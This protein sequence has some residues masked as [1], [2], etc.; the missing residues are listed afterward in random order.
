MKG[1]FEFVKNGAAGLI[2]QHGINLA[3]FALGGISAKIAADNSGNI[4]GDVFGV[5]AK[6]IDKT[7]K[8]VH[9]VNEITEDGVP[10]PKFKGGPFSL[11]TKTLFY[12]GSFP[13]RLI[14]NLAHG[15]FKTVVPGAKANGS[16]VLSPDTILM[17]KDVDGT[18]VY[19][20][21][22]AFWAHFKNALVNVVVAL[23]I[24]FIVFLAY[25]LGEGLVTL[26]AV[27]FLGFKSLS[28]KTDEDKKLERRLLPS[29]STKSLPAR[30][31]Y[32]ESKIYR[33][34]D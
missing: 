21:G 27:S 3:K 9:T 2:Q 4:V 12:A 8:V 5:V 23:T 30:S 19:N 24:A 13:F 25:K 16:E 15:I 6:A 10:Q 26:I 34:K 32:E 1:L 31:S 28:S 33:F 22:A 18:F 7:E 17:V 20:L 29:E 11:A 14:N